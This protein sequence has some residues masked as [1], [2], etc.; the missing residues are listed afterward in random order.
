MPSWRTCEGSCLL[1]THQ[2]LYFWA[3][4]SALERADS[5][6]E[7]LASYILFTQLKIRKQKLTSKLML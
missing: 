1:S 3:T 4:N 6:L 2:S 5:Y 7:E